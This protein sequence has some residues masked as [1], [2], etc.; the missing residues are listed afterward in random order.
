[1]LS[2][3]H[4]NNTIHSIHSID[5]LYQGNCK[6]FFKVPCK[7]HLLSGIAMCYNAMLV[8]S[9]PLKGLKRLP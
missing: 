2:S 5:L 6:R 4:D 1:M 8:R 3:I 9:Q 7:Q